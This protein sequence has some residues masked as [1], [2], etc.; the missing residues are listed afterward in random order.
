MAAASAAY[1]LALALSQALIAL[2]GHARAALG[3]LAAIVAM[4][5]I[6]AMGSDLLLR[7]ELGLVGGSVVAM[8]M[9]AVLLGLSIRR[10][11]LPSAETLVAAMSPEH[12]IIEP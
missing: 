4:A 6:I 10:A 5:V 1:M 8:G 9:M 3:W 11:D 12:E 7:V 2:S